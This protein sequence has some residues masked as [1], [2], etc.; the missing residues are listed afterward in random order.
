MSS[1]IAAPNETPYLIHSAS[2]GLPAT[3]FRTLHSYGI[4]MTSQQLT[5]APDES[6]GAALCTVDQ[7]SAANQHLYAKPSQI[8]WLTRDRSANGLLEYGAVVEGFNNG[9]RPSIY[10]HAPSWFRWMRAGG[11][12]AP[13]ISAEH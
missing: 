3:M 4:A 11:S 2:D 7:F 5:N 6:F 9:T 12:K 1:S 13:R 10:I 8:R